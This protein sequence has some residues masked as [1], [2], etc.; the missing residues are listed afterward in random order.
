MQTTLINSPVQVNLSL[1][2]WGREQDNVLGIEKWGKQP[3]DKWGRQGYY[4][5][6]KKYGGAGSKILQI[7]TKTIESRVSK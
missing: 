4:G 7:W 3:I 5:H 1:E 2:M 6:F